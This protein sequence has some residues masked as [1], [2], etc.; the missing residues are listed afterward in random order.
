M[1][2]RI[3]FKGE[4]CVMP[5]KSGKDSKGS[6]YQWGNGKKFYYQAG[7][8]ESREEAKEKADKQGRAVYASGYKKK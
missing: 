2:T 5:T 6:Y 1:F 8:K 3:L 7:D 4:W